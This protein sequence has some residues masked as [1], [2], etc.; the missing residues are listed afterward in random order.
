MTAK[1][2]HSFP[3]RN[4]FRLVSQN[5]KFAIVTCILQ[6]L[7]IPLIMGSSMLEVYAS[8]KEHYYSDTWAYML[9]GSFCLSVSV[10]LG[11]FFGIN[12]YRE[13]WDKSKVDML[14]ALPLTGKQRFFSNYLGGLGMYLIPYLI[15]VGLGWIVIFALSPLVRSVLKPDELGDL[16]QIYKYYLLFTAGL[17]LLMWMYYTIS[18]LIASCC[19]TLF[20]NIYTNVLL[21]LLVPGTL[22]AILGVV[23]SEMETIKF[24]YSWDFIGHT[25]P[26]GGLIYLFY[27]VVTKT[28]ALEYYSSYYSNTYH[29]VAGE[30]GDMGLIP[31]YLRWALIIALVT[32]ALL[33][34]AWRL[35]EHRKA[36]HVSK[37]FVYIGIYYIILTA[38]T[39]CILCIVEAEDDA[40]IP[41]LIFSAIVYF[42]MEVIRKRGFKKFWLSAVSYVITVVV[43]FAGMYSISATNAFGRAYYI[44]ALSS[45]NSVKLEL[46]KDYASSREIDYELNFNDKEMIS[47]I[48]DFQRDCIDNRKNGYEATVQNALDGYYEL[49]YSSD[50]D[51]Q[52]RYSIVT[53]PNYAPYVQEC[54]ELNIT[55]YTIT[56]SAIHRSYELLADEYIN[57]MDICTSTDLYA[58]ATAN[59]L[60]NRLQKTYQK[61]SPDGTKY[62]YPSTVSFAVTSPLILSGYYYDSDTTNVQK[63][64][65]SDVEANFSLLTECYQRD[66]T[67]MTSEEYRTSK[68]ICQIQD[69]PVRE[70]NQETCALLQKW[71]LREFTLQEYFNI[72]DT[73]ESSILDIRIYA[74]ETYITPS[75]QYPSSTI[76]DFW[77]R[78]DNSADIPSYEDIIPAGYGNYIFDS[79]LQEIHPEI[80]DLLTSARRYYI[81]SEPC[82]ALVINGRYYIIPPEYSELAEEVIAKGD[83]YTYQ[84]AFSF[85]DTPNQNYTYY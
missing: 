68:I 5:K 82:Y 3:T 6:L 24:E 10:L 28:E 69:I 52:T 26:I 84:S 70:C 49:D 12:A 80:Y 20:E 17:C 9:I 13:E 18:A 79:A 38:V 21:N 63:I 64:K 22:A 72:D 74:P 34:L 48:Q 23:T 15:A 11:I 46:S 27:L 61:S 53:D 8:H 36:E 4:A 16:N 81:S 59:V 60:R 77:F 76:Q 40:L 19:G 54:A 73:Y 62:T 32:T 66:L 33:F 67:N 58:E 14:Y 25:S 44:P 45:V 2:L 56:G 85:T 39:I 71:G 57:L 29:A 50:F 31:A 55:Y 42:I 7:G 43:A 41:V 37:P 35:Y 83:Y 30:L 51:L 78:Q 75:L 65:L 1:F 47:N